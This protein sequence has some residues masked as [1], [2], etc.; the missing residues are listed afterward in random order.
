MPPTSKT[1]AL[2]VATFIEH[3]HGISMEH[4]AGIRFTIN[5]EGNRSGTI[6]LRISHTPDYAEVVRHIRNFTKTEKCEK[7]LE[8]ITV[9]KSY[10]TDPISNRKICKP[11]LRTVYLVIRLPRMVFKY[12]ST[13]LESV[14]GYGAIER[15][16]EILRT[17]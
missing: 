7:S 11:E 17:F 13:E 4:S 10:Q 3:I 8:Q 5:R 15:I 2:R 16:E 12:I 1:K 6:G 14:K 9:N